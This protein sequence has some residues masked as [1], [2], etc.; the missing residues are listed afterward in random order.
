[1]KTKLKT[2]RVRCDGGCGELVKRDA[3]VMLWGSFCEKCDKRIVNE[4]ELGI[5]RNKRIEE[6]EHRQNI[7][8][9]EQRF[10]VE[11]IE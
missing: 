7:K 3:G 10:N 8:E 4:T 11:I 6:K 2:R 5:E 9:I 1:M